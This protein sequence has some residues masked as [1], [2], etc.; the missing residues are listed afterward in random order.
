MHEQE[1]RDDDGDQREHE[2][3]DRETTMVSGE[4]TSRKTETTMMSGESTGRESSSAPVKAGAGRATTEGESETG[5]ST[6]RA[7]AA[8]R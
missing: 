6:R 5:G 8:R 7:A 1:D 2:R 4:S 3:E